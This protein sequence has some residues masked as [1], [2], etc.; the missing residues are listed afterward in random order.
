MMKELAGFPVAADGSFSYRTVMPTWLQNSE[1]YT[2]EVIQQGLFIKQAQLTVGSTTYR[3]FMSYDG[4]DG[5]FVMV[6]GN[7]NDKVED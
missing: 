5:G 7:V 1:A 2:Q 4:N 3:T 6:T